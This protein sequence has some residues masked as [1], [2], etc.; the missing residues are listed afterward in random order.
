[1]GGRVSDVAQLAQPDL[2]FVRVDS[3][4][5][6]SR[7]NRDQLRAQSTQRAFKLALVVVAHVAILTAAWNVVVESKPAPLIRVNLLAI[8]S[9]QENIVAPTPKIVAQKTPPPKQTP[10]KPTERTVEIAPIETPTFVPAPEVPMLAPSNA[11]SAV[12]SASANA[13]PTASPPTVASTAPATPPV[14]AKPKVELP[15]SDADYLSNP[16]PPYPPVSK[17][18]KEQGRVLLRVFVSA[19]GSAMQVELRQTS[20]FERLDTIAIETVKRWKFVPGK[21]DGVVEAMWVTVPII[22]ELSS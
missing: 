8:D 14:P 22:F 12:T 17:R 9:P 21:R 5:A 19:E 13:T 2:T 4:V 7:S 15:S 1:V 20:G 18:L 3:L 6:L 16:A 11:T 10:T